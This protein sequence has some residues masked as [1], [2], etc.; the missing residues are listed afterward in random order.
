M[1]V[2][3]LYPIIEHYIGDGVAGVKRGHDEVSFLTIM[4]KDGRIEKNE[5]GDWDLLVEEEKVAEIED[6][7]FSIFCEAKKQPPIDVYY[8]K[9]LKVKRKKLNYRSSIL[10]EQLVK[11]LEML[12]LNMEVKLKNPIAIG[13]FL[14]F[15]SMGRKDIIVLN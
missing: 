7:L 5:E 10:V 2:D 6:S 14:V 11:S 8:K 4:G 9:L 12:M 13:P 15:T 3:I 1:I